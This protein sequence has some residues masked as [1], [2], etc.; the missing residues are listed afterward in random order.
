MDIANFPSLT[1]EEFEEACH[2]LDRRYR[3]AT[4]GDMRKR[5]KLNVRTA[6]NTGVVF[7]DMPRTLVEIT[8]TLDDQDLGLDLDNL[9]ISRSDSLQDTPPEADYEMMED[10]ASDEVLCDT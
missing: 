2:Y 3:R 7:H 8:R 5:W 1:G 10:E 6:L 9:A 4:L